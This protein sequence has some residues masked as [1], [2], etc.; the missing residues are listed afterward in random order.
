[1]WVHFNNIFSAVLQQ[2][3]LFNIIMM[4][5]INLHG[6]NGALLASLTP[7]ATFFVFR[8]GSGVAEY[9]IV[10]QYCWCLENIFIYDT[11]HFFIQKD[12]LQTLR[13]LHRPINSISAFKFDFL[14]AYRIFLNKIKSKFPVKLK[15]KDQ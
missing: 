6:T 7:L 4:M 5:I 13:D 11:I 1:M 12:T 14:K 9:K 10:C 8:Y 3:A 2:I 15:S